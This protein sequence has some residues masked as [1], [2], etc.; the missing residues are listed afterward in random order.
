MPSPMCLGISVTTQRKA[1]LQVNLGRFAPVNEGARVLGG[2]R[3]SASP[4]R[5]IVGCEA[6]SMRE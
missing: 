2:W 5:I 6:T 1:T 4:G 3:F